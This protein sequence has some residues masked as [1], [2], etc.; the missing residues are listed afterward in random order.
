MHVCATLRSAATRLREKIVK[1]TKNTKNIKRKKSESR[2]ISHMRGSALIQPI[3]IEIGTSVQV[4]NV[5]YHA[6]FCGYRLRGLDFA[7]S[8]I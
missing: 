1:K 2:Y 8:R 7:K 6:N 5:I 3:A 4:P